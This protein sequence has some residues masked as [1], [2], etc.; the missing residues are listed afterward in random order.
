MRWLIHDYGGQEYQHVNHPMFLS[1]RNSIYV[2]V[3]P[4][5]LSDLEGDSGGREYE[6]ED[7]LM[8]RYKYWLKFLNSFTPRDESS[9]SVCITLINKFTKRFKALKGKGQAY[10]DAKAKRVAERIR[11]LQ[12]K[13]MYPK[14]NLQFFGDPLPIDA[15]KLSR[16]QGHLAPL[17]ID[18]L[19]VLSVKAQ[20]ENEFLESI[21][22]KFKQMRR[23]AFRYSEFAEVV[24]ENHSLL[25][26]AYKDA[27]C[28]HV[29][30]K[31]AAKNELVYVPGGSNESEASATD[32]R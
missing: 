20:P 19:R 24:L 6:D 28:K 8:E 5:W 30:D 10:V 29:L 3:V 14:S 17:L 25:S 12:M 4:L 7:A 1:K 26:P 16:V 15:R 23:K 32:D 13:L 9:G 11:Q 22:L 18:A 2:I 27:V 21:V 31:L